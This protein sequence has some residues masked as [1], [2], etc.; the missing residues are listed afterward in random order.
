MNPHFVLMLAKLR[1]PQHFADKRKKGEWFSVSFDDAVD[2]VKA[3]F[4]DQPIELN[5]EFNG[6][7]IRQRASDNYL[8]ATA[9]CQANGKLFADY[10]RLKT[11]QEF[12]EALSL[13]MGI[14]IIKLIQV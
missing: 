5:R 12:L 3:H 1:K 7:K 6:I 8:D 2:F 11:T 9:M 10:Q 14:P 4:V 13:N